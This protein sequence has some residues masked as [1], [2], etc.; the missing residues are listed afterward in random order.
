MFFASA[1][2]LVRKFGEVSGRD[3]E[4]LQVRLQGQDYVITGHF[5]GCKA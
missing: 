2:G 5:D 4:K 1:L 3:A